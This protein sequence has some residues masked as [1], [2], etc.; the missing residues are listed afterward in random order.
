MSDSDEDVMLLVVALQEESNDT[1]TW[2][3]RQRSRRATVLKQPGTWVML[4]RFNEAQIDMLTSLLHLASHFHT[5]SRYDVT[6]KE[7]LCMLL[8]P[9]AYPNRLGELECA[10]SRKRSAIS[11]ITNMVLTHIYDHFKHLLRFDQHGYDDHKLRE[12]AAKARPQIPLRG[13]PNGTTSHLHGPIPGVRH[14]AYLLSVSSRYDLLQGDGKQFILYGD[15]AYGRQDYILAP[16]K[17]AI[18]TSEQEEFN[19]S[20]REVRVCV[21]WEFGRLLRYWAF[22]D[23]RKNQK[24]NLQATGKQYAVI[25]LF[26][27]VHGCMHG[28]Q[29][30]TFFGLKPPSVEEYLHD[31]HARQ[32]NA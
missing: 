18:L 1:A 29:T 22:C 9:M 13:D 7:A 21:E 32:Q 16:F 3:R 31:E 20:M 12:F 5:T 8:R 15:P 10:F 19:S 25:A 11:Q 2:H 4:Y 23:F 27:N 30:A 26:S 24:L 17:G 6:G 28:N 14:D